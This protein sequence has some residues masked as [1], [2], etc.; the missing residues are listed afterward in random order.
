MI[1]MTFPDDKLIISAIALTYPCKN[2][3]VILE[4]GINSIKHFGPPFMHL[5]MIDKRV[6]ANTSGLF[7]V[8]PN[9]CPP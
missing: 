2:E 6:F 4:T 5:I 1:A 7:S 9:M 8:L 3:E